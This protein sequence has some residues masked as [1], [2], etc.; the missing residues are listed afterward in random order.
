LLSLQGSWSDS[1]GR[2]Y[3]LSLHHANVSN[4]HSLGA[5]IL[6][7]TPVTI[8]LAEARVSLPLRWMKLD[9]AGRLQDDQ[10]PPRHGFAAS[11][12]AGL[13]IGL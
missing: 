1:G 6:T 5:N 7:P 4:S 9:L 12:E 2:F 10:L 8:D 3:E 13:R 11:F